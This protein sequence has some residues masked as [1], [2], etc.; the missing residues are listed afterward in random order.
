MKNKMIKSMGMTIVAV[1]SLSNI[2]VAEQNSTEPVPVVSAAVKADTL[3][4]VN[5]A[6]RQRMLSQRMAKDYMYVGNKVAVSK[7]KKQLEASVKEFKKAHDKLVNSINNEDIKNLL[8][9]VQMSMEDFEL[10]IKEPFTTDNAQ[11]VLDLSESILEGSQYVVASLREFLNI[12]ASKIVDISGRQRMLSQRISKYYIAYQSGIKD[13]NTV[14]QMNET[15]T[16][17]AE[18]HKLLMSNKENTPEVNRKLNEIDKL[19]K[20]VNK[21]YLNIEKGGL[22]HIVFSTTDKITKK[23]N[24]VTGLYV[25]IYK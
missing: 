10:M 23:M 16:L 9:F 17:F 6:G 14:D 2:A 5:I 11:L 18:S 13:K 3:K 12:K 21:F 25:E 4:L 15:V 8:S 1:L 20:I 24:E 22:P 7:A 19:W